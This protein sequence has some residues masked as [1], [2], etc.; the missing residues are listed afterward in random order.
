[1]RKMLLIFLLMLTT[2]AFAQLMNPK[3]AVQQ[4][5]HDFGTIKQGDKV[6]HSFIISNSGGDVLKILDVKA[7][8]GCTAANPDKKELGPGES[9]K[10]IVSFDS[11]GRKGPQVKTVRVKTNDP[12]NKE[13][14][15]TFRCNIEIPN[16]TSNKT[17]ALIYFP[18]SQ[19]NFGKVEEGKKVTH[20]FEF[21]NNGDD[22]L[23]IKDVK[24]SCGCTAAL[25]SS[26]NLK[27]GEKGTI[28]VELDT[29]NRN[30][31]M[32]RTLTVSSN[33]TRTPN[34][35]ITLFADVTKN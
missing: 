1:M 12:D 17:G 22:I 33:D 9:T 15:F 20:T 2:S 7:S 16:Q 18:E 35:V 13:I 23:E 8:C 10:I 34:K 21:V 26:S 4:L 31:K 24:T 6:T 29:K 28:K 30:G 3:V 25:V 32:S 11:K 19:H 5:E 27:P 14:V